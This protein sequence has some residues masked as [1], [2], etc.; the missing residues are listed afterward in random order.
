M[1]PG[2]IRAFAAAR[3]GPRSALA[4][5]RAIQGLV[6]RRSFGY[7]AQWHRAPAHPVNVV[8]ALVGHLVP[9]LLGPSGERTVSPYGATVSGMPGVGLRLAFLRLRTG[10]D[11]TIDDLNSTFGIDGHL[12]FE[13]GGGG[14]ARV[15]I[16]NAFAT[17]EVYLHGAHLTAYQPRGAEGLVWLSDLAEFHPGKAIRGGIPI[18]WPWFGPHPSRPDLPQHGFA[19]TSEWAVWGSRALPDGRTELRL[20]LAGNDTKRLQWHHAFELDVRFLVG[21]R[22]QV[23]LTTRNTGSNAVEIG[24]A[25]HTYFRV[26][27]VERISIEGLGGRRYIDQVDGHKLKRTQAAISISEE[28]DRVYMDTSDECVID[29]PEFGRR[30]RVA[31]SG[32]LSTVVW[33]PWIAKAKRMTDFPDEGYRRM[34]CVETANAARDARVL[35]P[36]GVHTLRQTISL[37]PR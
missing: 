31:K 29:D 14:L 13:A 19:R 36:G 11:V 35:R 10:F 34:V 30:I 15:V 9:P 24:S 22:L 27:D 37:E 7:P 1:V 21:E 4:K 18:V 32:S 5:Q 33:N 6:G 26:G 25:L 20:R 8:G 2:R 23:E 17:A 12:A 3:A 28:V 16:T